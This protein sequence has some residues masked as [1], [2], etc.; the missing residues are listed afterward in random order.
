MKKI[1]VYTVQD[2]ENMT[3]LLNGLSVHGIQNC[4]NIAVIAQILDSGTSAEIQE[5]GRTEKKD[6][7]E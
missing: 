6:G 2:V 3:A 1:I 5:A 7:E 4:K